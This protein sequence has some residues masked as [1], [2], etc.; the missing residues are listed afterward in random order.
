[1]CSMV[2]IRLG[3]RTTS[4]RSAWLLVTLICSLGH[5]RWPVAQWRGIGPHRAENGGRVCRYGTLQAR[6]LD[7]I[8]AARL[9]A[10]YTQVVYYSLGATRAGQ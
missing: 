10:G 8:I 2:P 5:S 1:M 3:P 6:C 4:H 9:V 7:H